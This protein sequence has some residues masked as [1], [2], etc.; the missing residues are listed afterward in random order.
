MKH[1]ILTFF[2]I[3]LLYSLFFN[4]KKRTAPAEKMNYLYE[5]ASPV[6]PG[7]FFIP[8]SSFENTHAITPYEMIWFVSELH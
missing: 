4:D 8:D 7:M 1:V 3:V 5:N 6:S 2:G